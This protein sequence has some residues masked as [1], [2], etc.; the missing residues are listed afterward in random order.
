MKI[1]L[2]NVNLLNPE[3]NLNKITDLLIEDGKIA[4]IG[5]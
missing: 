3:Q 2:K 1:V 5:D 4:R